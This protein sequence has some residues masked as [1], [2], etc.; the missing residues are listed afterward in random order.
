[1]LLEF[2]LSC[3]MSE[4]EF[5]LALSDD[6]SSYTAGL[7]ALSCPAEHS[8]DHLAFGRSVMD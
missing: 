7:I 2:H 6:G 1:M 5:F 8:P 4:S 3:I